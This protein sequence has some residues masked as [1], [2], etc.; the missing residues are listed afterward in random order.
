MTDIVKNYTELRVWQAA[1]DLVPMIY[2]ITEKL[3][4]REHYTL[5]QQMRRAAVSVPANVAEGQARQHTREFLH[6]LS[7]A[8][9][10]LAELHTMLLLAGRLS[11]LDGEQLEEPLRQVESIRMLLCGLFG[12]L[13]SRPSRPTLVVGGRVER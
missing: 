12:R 4:G 10:S 5:G 8:R 2:R 11:Y 3:P 7:I 1:M 13:R 9:G 6:H